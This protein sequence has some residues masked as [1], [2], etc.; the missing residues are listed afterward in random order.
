[1][2]RLLRKVLLGAVALALL[3]G[4]FSFKQQE[5]IYYENKIPSAFGSLEPVVIH[6]D[7]S[8]GLL[9]AESCGVAIFRFSDGVANKINVEKLSFFAKATIARG[10]RGTYQSW[11]ATP[12]PVN[13]TDNGSWI[14]CFEHKL[15]REIIKAATG[16]GSYYTTKSEAVLLVIP[17]LRFIVFSFYG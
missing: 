9:R 10:H 1:M 11:N 5:R 16:E 8:L 7:T 4:Y 6:E 2:V 15:H 14:P 12:V 17:R 3:W 13:W